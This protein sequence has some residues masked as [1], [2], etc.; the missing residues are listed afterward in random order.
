MIQKIRNIKE[1]VDLNRRWIVAILASVLIFSSGCAGYLADYRSAQDAFNAAA[2]AENRQKLSIDNPENA[3]NFAEAGNIRSNYALSYKQ[4]AD[5]LNA[6]RSDLEKDQLLGS[7]LNIKALCEWKLGKYADAASTATEALTVMENEGTVFPRDRAML[8]ALPGLIKA[9]QAYYYALENPSEK[10]YDDIKN[11]M[12]GAVAD[13]N[14]AQ[15]S[16]DLSHPVQQYLLSSRL[17]VYRTWQVA[18]EEKIDNDDQ[19]F[20]ARRAVRKE[21]KSEFTRFENAPQKQDEWNKMISAFTESG[22]A[23]YWSNLLGVTIP[24][25]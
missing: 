4:I 7:A 18:I 19:R 11:L 25:N 17:A 5:L 16:V 20:E 12:E 22:A 1:S 3:A 21:I 10:S 15:K 23:A 9:D 13:F 8:T 6:K 2:E 24:P 14:H